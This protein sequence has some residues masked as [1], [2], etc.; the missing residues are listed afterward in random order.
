MTPEELPW[1]DLYREFGK[2]VDQLGFCRE[3]LDVS[4]RHHKRAHDSADTAWA[5]NVKLRKRVEKVEAELMQRRLD[6]IEQPHA[7]VMRDE[8]DAA[9]RRADKAEARVRELEALMA[10]G[11]A[12]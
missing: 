9:L 6:I 4:R 5:E 7:L 10:A 11:R 3:E 1:E 2:A 8:R 12:K